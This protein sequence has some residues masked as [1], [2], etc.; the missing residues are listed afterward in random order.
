MCIRDRPGL[1]LGHELVAQVIG[2][3][4]VLGMDHDQRTALLGLLQR[5]EQHLSLIHI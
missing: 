5:L 4:A 1:A 3:I 2:C